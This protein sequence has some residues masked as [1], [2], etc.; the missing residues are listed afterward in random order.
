M[1]RSLIPLLFILSG[2]AGLIFEVV[3]S[4][5]LVLV[6][7]NTTQS[8]STILTGFFGGMAV[9]SW[10]GGKIAD[11]TKRPL[12][13]YG[14][15]EVLL[16]VIVL[17]TPL[18]FPLIH[19]AYRSL[20][21]TLASAP[22]RIALVRFALAIIALSPATIMMGATLPTLTRYLARTNAR[23][24]TEFT[25]LYV[26]NTMGAVFGA[27]A[28]GLVL[29]E[30]LGLNGALRVGAACS[31]IAGLTAIALEFFATDNVPEIES[32]DISRVE[33]RVSISRIAFIFAFVSGFTSLAYQVLWTRL[34]ASGTGSSTY[35]FTV[36]LTIFL[37]GLALGGVEYKRIGARVKSVTSMLAWLQ[38]GIAFIAFGGMYA[39]NA[40]DQLPA[41]LI[42]KSAVV[43]LPATFAMGF[44]FP[45]AS[46][47]IKGEDSEVG[48]KAGLLVAANTIG[49]ILATFVIP[50]VLIASF[51]SP[52]V[53]AFVIVVNAVTAILIAGFTRQVRRPI[54][55]A[56]AALILV[57]AVGASA[58][59][60]RIF[61][62]PGVARVIR[63]G[64]KVY[65]SREDNFASVQAGIGYGRE[66]WVTGFSMTVLTV[67]AKLMPVLPLMFKPSSQSALVIAFGMGSAFRSSLIAGL[68]TDAVELVPSVPKMFD[69][70]YPDAERV[71]AN[72]R[73]RVVIAD[74]RSVVELTKNRYDIIVVDPPPPLQSAGVSIISSREFYQASRRRL[75]SG[76]IMM[77]WV[78]W[79]QTMSDFK[80]HVRTFRSVF[81]NVAVFAGPGG[82][83]FF[84]LGSDSPLALRPSDIVAVLSRPGVVPDLSSAG[85]S[86]A[87]TLEEWTAL[88]PRLLRIGSSRVV[89]FVGPGRLITDD[90][91]LPEYFLLGALADSAGSLNRDLVR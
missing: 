3:W 80:N 64:G 54:I 89:S 50:F 23:L 49:A 88:I 8:V 70:F 85:D 27:A 67:D 46:S 15:L 12:L 52:H 39:I 60:D 10:I 58:L 38:L 33:K 17:L 68:R 71:L 31:L 43:V 9:G 76:G 30:L 91:P 32:A 26:A 73:G 35:V 16:A 28:A 66:L 83:G 19:S 53:L 29:I 61:V 6:F 2:A 47:L 41:S 62:D 81:P 21:I 57:A 37:L 25:R 20:F 86:P 42:W 90:R 75:T 11:H 77:Q 65:R 78:P 14:A 51:G 56:A 69:V 18:T 22:N 63:L 24:G 40:L 48:G 59:S 45:A 44:S 13:L 5:Q 7:G 74:G 34:L 87:K 1:K 84:I 36:I 4:R 82:N 79:Q 55:L 72:P